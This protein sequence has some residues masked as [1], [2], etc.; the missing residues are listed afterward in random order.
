MLSGMF[1][2]TIRRTGL[3]LMLTCLTAFTAV[4]TG[5]T[6]NP[7]TGRTFLSVLSP[8]QEAQLGAEAAP[9]LRQQFGG[10]VDHPQLQAYVTRVGMSM[11]P[12]TEGYFREMEWEFTLL[13]S[14]VINAFALP[15]GK[16]FI[17]RGLV[18]RMDSEAQLAGVLGHEIGHVTAQ[19]TS[20]RISQHLGLN[21]GL[22]L[23]GL[24]VGM[25][26]PGG[27]VRQVGEMAL[28]AL[29]IGGNLVLLSFNRNEESEA[30]YLGMR[31]MARAGYNPRGQ[32][33]VMEILRDASERSPRQLEWMA[34]HPLPET[35][36]RQIE[37]RLES[38]E[39]A[40]AAAQLPMH[41]ERFQ[42]EFLPVL[43]QLPPPQ[44]DRPQGTAPAAGQRIIG[45]GR[46]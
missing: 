30:D 36:I 32:L 42:R 27:D 31:Y 35:R 2:G 16:V 12:H 39:F 37:R 5:C 40:P 15:G 26:D 28:P 18:D 3:A 6:T 8:A 20:Q 19:H 38:P 45:P 24:L 11:V 23:G 22:A 9:E 29:A 4:P 13:D 17:T 10:A 25:A 44:Q 33:Q 1:T 7:A 41:E 43:A 14:G 34:T 21:L 46:N